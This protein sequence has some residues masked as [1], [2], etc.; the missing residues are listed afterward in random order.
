M[1][2]SSKPDGHVC[3]II[4]L[5]L[6]ALSTGAESALIIFCAKSG[7]ALIFV[8]QA[9]WPEVKIVWGFYS[10]CCIYCHIEYSIMYEHSKENIRELQPLFV[11]KSA[12]AHL[13][14]VMA[15]FYWAANGRRAQMQLLWL[16]EAKRMKQDLIKWILFEFRVHWK[17]EAGKKANMGNATSQQKIVW[18]FAWIN[19][20]SDSVV[21][22]N[23]LGTVSLG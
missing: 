14:M 4:L 2:T 22:H 16:N 18:A 20:L 19:S 23:P 6:C 10:C 1:P 13:K 11:L 21:L 3:T 7:L 9:I 12:K 17:F 8:D 15:N 5:V